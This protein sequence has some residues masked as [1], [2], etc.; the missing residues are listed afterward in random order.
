MQIDLSNFLT[1]VTILGGGFAA[2]VQLIRSQDL[3]R[4]SI[5]ERDTQKNSDDLSEIKSKDI[6]EI[7]KDLEKLQ[8]K[9][10]LIE[11]ANGFSEKQVEE[12]KSVVDKLFAY[13]NEIR[14]DTSDVRETIA[15]FSKDYVTRK[16][17]M[18]VRT[19]NAK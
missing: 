17:Y 2:L 4:I 19:R 11:Q 6:A 7:R 15:G 12:I 10:T 1:I 5:V 18:D 14:E 9:I 13:I 16:E 3:K 8:G